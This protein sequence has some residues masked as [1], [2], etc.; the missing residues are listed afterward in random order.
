MVDK[1]LRSPKERLL[2]PLAARFPHLHP[3]VVTLVAF[4]VGVLC[5]LALCF[6]AYG[7]ALGLWIVNRV[8]DG[9]DGTLARV[10]NKQSDFGGYIDILLDTVIYAG[11]PICL[12]LA[13]PTLPN[14]LALA[15][16]LASFYINGASWMYLSALLEKRAQG[17]K[18]G[19]EMT[20]VTMP[21][22]L[23]EGAETILF[24]AAFMLLPTLLVPLFGLMAGLVFITVGQRL[25]WAWQVLGKSQP[26][27]LVGTSSREL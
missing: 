11:V 8:L 21:S 6:Q 3:T 14:A 7:L 17:A 19:G 18:A 10:H 26:K 2:T 22:G 9:L 16:L 15:G 23:V 24:Y 20:T 25:V 1:E 4:G 12:V 5:C 13:L 27:E